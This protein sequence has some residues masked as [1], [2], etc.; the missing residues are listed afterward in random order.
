MRV[1]GDA[2]LSGFGETWPPGYPD[3]ASTCGPLG[4][5]RL[6]DRPICTR[7][8]DM[9]HPPA[10]GLCQTDCRRRLKTGPHG[11]AGTRGSTFG[12]C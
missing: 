7:A 2:V 9:P 8:V 4:R 10:D 12:R 11:R 3:A 6:A 5:M 1:N